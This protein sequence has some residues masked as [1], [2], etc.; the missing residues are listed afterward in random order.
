MR[1]HM[2][3]FRLSLQCNKLILEYALKKLKSYEIRVIYWRNW[4]GGLFKKKI[5]Y[6]QRENNWIDIYRQGGISCRD[7]SNKCE[8]CRSSVL[9][10]NQ[11]YD[12]IKKQDETNR[13]IKLVPFAWYPQLKKC[14][15]S[16][17]IVLGHCSR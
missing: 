11:D 15:F 17:L 14:L 6:K 13:K 8:I 9:K 12:Q 1:I 16:G 5:P 3:N 10:W 4:S 7:M 2:S